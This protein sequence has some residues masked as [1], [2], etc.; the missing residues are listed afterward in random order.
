M[1]GRLWCSAS[2]TSPRQ[3]CASEV[4]RCGNGLP[5]PTNYLGALK[6]W[7]SFTDKLDTT[8]QS[9]ETAMTR[10]NQGREKDSRGLIVSSQLTVGGLFATSFPEWPT[11]PPL[12]RVSP[13]PSVVVG[14]V[15]FWSRSG[16]AWSPVTVP[17]QRTIV[18]STWVKTETAGVSLGQSTDRLFPSTQVPCDPVITLHQR[19]VHHYASPLWAA[20]SA[21]WRGFHL[22]L[23]HW[24]SPRRLFSRGHNPSS[25][26]GHAPP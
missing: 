12:T 11:I 16:L 26:Y 18:P 20:R 7:R 1:P 22:D 8:R 13:V 4:L 5:N 14:L 15:P 21:N 3:H 10:P 19:L 25:R 17:S 2:Q 6:H 9:R 24:S 23:V